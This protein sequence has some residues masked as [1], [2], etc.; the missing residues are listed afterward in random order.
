MHSLASFMVVIEGDAAYSCCTEEV[1]QHVGRTV[2][3]FAVGEKEIITARHGLAPL[4]AGSLRA[5]ALGTV[6]GAAALGVYL[7]GRT[8][9]TSDIFAH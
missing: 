5:A 3:R 7:L 4:S 6:E 2:A 9:F 8:A 1:E